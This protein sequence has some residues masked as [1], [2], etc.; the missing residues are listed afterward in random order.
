MWLQDSHNSDFSF[1]TVLKGRFAKVYKAGAASLLAAIDAGDDEPSGVVPFDK[2]RAEQQIVLLA[3][4]S[5]AL[6][7]RKTPSPS[8]TAMND[9]AVWAVFRRAGLEAAAEVRAGVPKEWRKLIAGAMRELN[10]RHIS[11]DSNNCESW[12]SDTEGLC[13]SYT[14]ES[15]AEDYEECLDNRRHAALRRE[16]YD[17]PDDYFVVPPP[18]PTLEE[19]EQ[20]RVTLSELMQPIKNT[21]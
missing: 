10:K 1:P 18:D 3:G 13:E 15:A 5:Q 14:R 2:L 17:L 6:L 9:L 11:I 8:L 7:D 20:A 19:V 16:G 4:V 12:V 21:K